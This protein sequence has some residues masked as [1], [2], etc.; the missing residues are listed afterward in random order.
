MREGAPLRGR[1][2]GGRLGGRRRCLF[3]GR[4]R[5]LG[6][7]LLGLLLR[8][9]LGFG[10]RLRRVRSG[11]GN[12][13]WLPAAAEQHHREDNADGYDRGDRDDQRDDQ[14]RIGFLRRLPGAV[15]IG[16]LRVVV[17]RRRRIWIRFGARR[18]GL[19]VVVVLIVLIGVHRHA[20][21]RRELVVE[22]VHVWGALTRL[23][24][25]AVHQRSLLRG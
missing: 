9:L 17:R 13:R 1:F 25:Q 4:F 3:G 5:L 23:Q 20:P 6:G 7:F 21:V 22:R 11:R 10:R 12:I 18:T 8:G 2:G 14:R 15:C 16:L 24:R 19:S